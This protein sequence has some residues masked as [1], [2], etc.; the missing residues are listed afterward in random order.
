MP[1]MIIQQLGSAEGPGSETRYLIHQTCL[2]VFSDSDDAFG[3]KLC[4]DLQAEG[5]RCRPWNENAKWG[6]VSMADTDQAI[7][8]YAKL[9]VVLSRSSSNAAAGSVGRPVDE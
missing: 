7:C 1:E 3:K 5:L 9:V 2:L 4:N 6:S 8:S